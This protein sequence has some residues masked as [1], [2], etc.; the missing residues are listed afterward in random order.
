M[1]SVN[2][3]SV[4]VQCSSVTNSG[5]TLNCTDPTSSVLFGEHIPI[6]IVTGLDGDVDKLS[7]QNNSPIDRVRLVQSVKICSS[8]VHLDTLINIIRRGAPKFGTGK[9]CLF[10]RQ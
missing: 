3:S 10:M 2:G 6:I 4:T 5:G 7:Q 9:K 8:K 1:V